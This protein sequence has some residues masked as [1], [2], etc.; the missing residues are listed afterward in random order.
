MFVNCGY[1]LGPESNWSLRD[2]PVDV[3]SEASKTT[4]NF[5]VVLDSFATPYVGR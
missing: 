3:H 5:V 4:L 1:K 2:I